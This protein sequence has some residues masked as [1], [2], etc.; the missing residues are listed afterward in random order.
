M[1]MR[2]KFETLAQ[3]TSQQL[4]AELQKWPRYQQ[5]DLAERGKLLQRLAEY[6]DR[7]HKVAENKA[8][9]LGLTLTPDQFA[10]F[11][12]KYWQKK[13]EA[14]HKLFDE[15]EPRRKALDQQI[16]AE[17]KQEFSAF[18]ALP[19]PSSSQPTAPNAAPAK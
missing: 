5:M 15:M 6:R 2:E 19:T 1:E 10:A 8:R 18:T 17:L 16:T 13:L 7:R 9:E 12:T 4:D 3:L 11:E 14:D